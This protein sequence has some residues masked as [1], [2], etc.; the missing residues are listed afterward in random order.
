MLSCCCVPARRAAGAPP[1][2]PMDGCQW[3]Q[4]AACRLRPASRD[5]EL[6][7]GVCAAGSWRLDGGWGI[8]LF[9]HKACTLELAASE[10]VLSA[11]T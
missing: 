5:V 3:A 10:P 11:I 9:A 8:C 2:L 4:L 1:V 6:Q 7:G